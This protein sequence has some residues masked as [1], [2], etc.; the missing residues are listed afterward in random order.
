MKIDIRNRSTRR[1]ISSVPLCPSQPAVEPRKPATNSL[2]YGTAVAYIYQSFYY[3]IQFNHL[4]A[5]SLT[6]SL[7]HGAEPF[8]RSRQLCSYSRNSQYC[9][10]TEGLL[11]CSQKPSTNPYPEPDQFNPSHFIFLRC[12]LILSNY[13]R[14]GVPSGILPSGFPTNILYT[15]FFSPIRAT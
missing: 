5:H 1:K 14:F 7:T 2:G 3:S 6:H 8:L 9:T 11:P 13:L 12:I 4:L 15:F 10:E